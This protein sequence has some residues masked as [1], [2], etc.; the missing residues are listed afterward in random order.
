MV[1][2]RELPYWPAQEEWCPVLPPRPHPSPS[3]CLWANQT[4][5]LNAHLNATKISIADIWPNQDKE[6]DILWV[7]LAGR[8][9]VKIQRIGLKA[10]CS[11]TPS[12]IFF[13][14]MTESKYKHWLLE[15]PRQLHVQK[16][17]KGHNKGCAWA[18]SGV[19]HEQHPTKL[20][21]Q[22]TQLLTEP[23]IVK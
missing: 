14:C 2:D 1:L 10:L 4:T 11:H 6:R 16:G 7:E 17:Y 21:S 3:L 23:L 15:W 13:L 9:T 20:L 18:S 5:C 22:F 12:N 19:T 8:T